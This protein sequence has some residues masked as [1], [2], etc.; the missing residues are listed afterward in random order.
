MSLHATYVG[1]NMSASGQRLARERKQPGRLPRLTCTFTE[2]TTRFEPATLTLAMRPDD[3]MVP[4]SC[5]Y[6]GIHARSASPAVACSPRRVGKVLATGG[7]AALRQPPPPPRLQRA[8]GHV[9]GTVLGSRQAAT[10]R[11]GL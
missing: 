1:K 4:L 5:G 6:A 2:R 10:H 9:S 8:A 11:S 3:R 7:P